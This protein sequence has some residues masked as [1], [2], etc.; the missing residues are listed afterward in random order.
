MSHRQGVEATPRRVED[1][2]QQRRNNGNHN[3]LSHTLWRIVR[4]WGQHVDLEPLPRQVRPARDQILS[5]IPLAIAG[6]V[7]IK[8]KRFEERVA[9]AHRETALRLAK[10]DFGRQRATTFEDSICPVDAQGA[11]VSLDLDTDQRAA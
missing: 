8:R 1:R 9:D 3:D 10:H 5:E 11:G 4:Q 2:V 6:S 7:F